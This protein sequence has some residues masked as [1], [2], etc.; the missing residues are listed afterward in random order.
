[1]RRWQPVLVATT[2]MV[3]SPRTTARLKSRA[4]SLSDDQ[5]RRLLLLSPA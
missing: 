5:R 4:S 3:G 1:M 2:N